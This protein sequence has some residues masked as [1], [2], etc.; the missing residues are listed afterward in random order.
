MACRFQQCLGPFSMLTVEQCS[1]TTLF[2]HLSNHV[3][4][5]L[6]F[7]KYI[8]YKV[9][10]FFL[11]MLKILWRCQKGSKNF[12]KRSFVSQ[13]IAFQLFF[14][15]LSLIRKEYLTLASQCVNRTVPGFQMLLRE[16]FFNFMS[17]RVM[18]KYDKSAVMQIPAV[19]GTLQHADCRTVF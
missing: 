13:V 2:R 16:I 17:L 19:F 5:S 3:Y 11:K 6:Q 10:Y 18:G 9:Y 14:C 1:E 15:K 4:G 12:R 7:R 8:S